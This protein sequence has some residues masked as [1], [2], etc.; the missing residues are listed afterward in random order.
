MH[1]KR[2]RDIV[3][4]PDFCITEATKNATP[5]SIQ[6]CNKWN[7]RKFKFTR[8]TNKIRTKSGKCVD[9]LNN[10]IVQSKCNNK[11]KTQK[12]KYKNKQF[13]SLA[14]KKCMDV[15]FGDYRK[16]ALIAYSCHNG[17]NQKFHA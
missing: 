2:V 12:W 13:C 7:R 14:N 4:T 15:E 5:L 16:G 8:K 17:P 1:K 11:V 3:H 6:P 10:R 9:I